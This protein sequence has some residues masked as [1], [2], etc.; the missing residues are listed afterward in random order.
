[1]ADLAGDLPVNSHGCVTSYPNT[2]AAATSTD[3]W[4]SSGCTYPG[5]A[6]ATSRTKSK[7]KYALLRLASAFRS[8]PVFERE[9]TEGECVDPWGSPWRLPRTM[10]VPPR[11]CIGSS[12][13]ESSSRSESSSE[14]SENI[15]FAIEAPSLALIP[16]FPPVFPSFADRVG[17]AMARANADHG[18]Y[19]LE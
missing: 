12:S 1:M 7:T 11:V 8:T 9:D 6:H 17:L 18:S 16:S 15:S 19:G 4:Y 10:W 3:W 5:A 14:D 13:A 2:S